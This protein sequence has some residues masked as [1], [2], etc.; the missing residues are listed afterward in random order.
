MP[1]PFDKGGKG[2]CDRK[3]HSGQLSIIRKYDVITGRRG[4]RPLQYVVLTI[5]NG[6]R[7]VSTNS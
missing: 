2:C 6:G 7:V 4:R 1:P 5:F 3:G